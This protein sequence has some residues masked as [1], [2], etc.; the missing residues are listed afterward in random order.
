MGGISIVVLGLIVL[1]LV[2]VVL[3]WWWRLYCRYVSSTVVAC[4]YVCTYLVVALVVVH[5]PLMTDFSF[6]NMAL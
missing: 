2:V 3:G 4:E 6:Y 5:L 1:L